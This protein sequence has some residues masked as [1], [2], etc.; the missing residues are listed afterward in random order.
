MLAQFC[1]TDVHCWWIVC[2]YQK[3][4]T[5]WSWSQSS[6]SPILFSKFPEKVLVNFGIFCEKL[7]LI[8]LCHLLRVTLEKIY[9]QQLLFLLLYFGKDGDCWVLLKC[10]LEFYWVHTP[11]KSGSPTAGMRAWVNTWG[12]GERSQEETSYGTLSI[13]QFENW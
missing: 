13:P 3:Y 1:N 7:C 4:D 9:E 2:L 11:H 5:W 8:R 6:S 12:A 10:L